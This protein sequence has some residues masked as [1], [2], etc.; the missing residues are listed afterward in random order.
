[1]PLKLLINIIGL[2]RLFGLLNLWERKNKRNLV[3]LIEDILKNPG[4]CYLKDLII[5]RMNKNNK[6]I[7]CS[8]L[9][10]FFLMHIFTK[11]IFLIFLTA[12]TEFRR[13][14]QCRTGLIVLQTVAY[15]KFK[16]APKLWLIGWRA[17][18]IHSHPISQTVLRKA[19]TTRLKYSSVTLMVS[20]TSSA[21]VIVFF[22]FSHT[23]I[24]N[25][26][27]PS[28]SPLV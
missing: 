25:K 12:K 23:K 3:K 28:P 2:G 18:L 14:R 21:S 1:M 10:Q 15:L 19:A 26:W 17:S 16:S 6:L 9:R 8:M 11:K 7:L 4:N 27:Q 22:I 5:F 13:K 24:K 20:P